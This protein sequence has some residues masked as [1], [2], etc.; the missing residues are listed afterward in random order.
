LFAGMA[1]CGLP[2]NPVNLIVTPLVFGIGVDYGVYVVA[3]AQDCGDIAVALRLAGRALFVTALT[4]AAG[5]GFLAL[6]RYPFLAG[7]GLLTGIGLLLCVA[8]AVVLLPALLTI[9]GAAQFRH[10][11]G[12]SVR[13]L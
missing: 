6:S 1:L 3:R 5:F 9:T 12:E 10:A 4:T 8:L 13:R 2:L 7:L 11:E